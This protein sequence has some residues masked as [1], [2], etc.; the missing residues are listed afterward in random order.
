MRITT[1]IVEKAVVAI[2]LPGTILDVVKADMPTRDTD[3]ATEAKED[4]EVENEGEGSGGK[5]KEIL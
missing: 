4:E 5:H 3:I 1:T 2:V